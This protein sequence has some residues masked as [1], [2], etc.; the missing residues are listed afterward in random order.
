MRRSFSLASLLL[1]TGLNPTASAAS[2]DVVD[3]PSALQVDLVF[4]RNGTYSKPADGYFPIV[5]AMHNA[6]FSAALGPMLEFRVTQLKTEANGTETKVRS[7]LTGYGLGYADVRNF[8]SDAG[9]YYW[10]YPI[11]EM[12]MPAEGPYEITWKFYAHNCSE[13]DLTK[14]QYSREYSPFE[15]T[16]RLNIG[17]DGKN[18]TDAATL[19]ED[20]CGEPDQSV[21]VQ[22]VKQIKM[23]SDERSGNKD[24]P[25]AEA[26]RQCTVLETHE[27]TPKPEACG[28]LSEEAAKKVL[29]EMKDQAKDIHGPT[30][31]LPGGTPSPSGAAQTG[32]SGL[33]VLVPTLCLVATMVNL[34][35]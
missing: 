3:Y 11:P 31:D 25:E 19:V 34:L 2:D 13:T 4:P 9:P 29:A 15:R 6:K 10:N 1:L 22:A 30:S 24:L 35:A 16:V 17:A 18:P 21:V 7:S 14:W 33:M 8:S 20:S 23:E 27:K 12:T 32:A 5:F 28:S 26:L